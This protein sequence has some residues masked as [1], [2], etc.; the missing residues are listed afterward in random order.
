MGVGIYLGDPGWEGDMVLAY[1]LSPR[2]LG[3]HCAR[4]A[5]VWREGKGEWGTEGPR[6]T[7]LQLFCG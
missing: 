7:G 4:G 1:T 2:P 5:A 3:A 6:G